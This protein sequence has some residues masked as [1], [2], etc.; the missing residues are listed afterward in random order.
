LNDRIKSN[1]IKDRIESTRITRPNNNYPNDNRINYPNNRPNG[2]EIFGQHSGK[3]LGQD[4]GNDIGFGHNSGEVFGQ[5]S[6]NKNIFGPNSGN[7]FGQYS[8]KILYKWNLKKNFK[9]HLE[10]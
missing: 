4:S 6:G 5:H 3:V 7:S 8:G 1:R 2:N 9:L 10:F